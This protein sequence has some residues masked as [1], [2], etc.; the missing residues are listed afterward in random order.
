MFLGRVT[1]VDGVWRLQ[2][3]ASSLSAVM[4]QYPAMKN[5]VD[6]CGHW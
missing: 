3:V 1:V 4:S 2:R 5:E 6:R